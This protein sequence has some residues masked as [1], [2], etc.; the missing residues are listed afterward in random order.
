MARINLNSPGLKVVEK[1]KTFYIRKKSVST[2]LSPLS[3]GDTVDSNGNPITTTTTTEFIPRTTT[4]TTTVAPTTT[5]TTAPII[6]EFYFDG[7]FD[8]DKSGFA[9][10]N[11]VGQTINEISF[12]YSIFANVIGL[13]ISTGV[14]VVSST[15]GG[16]SWTTHQ[17]LTITDTTGSGNY[18][19][20]GGTSSIIGIGNIS[21]LRIGIVGDYTLGVRDGNGSLVLNYV[22]PDTGS[23]I[24]I[25]PNEY[26]K[27]SVSTSVPFTLIDTTT[28]TTTTV[29]PLELRYSGTDIN[30]YGYFNLNNNVGGYN[31]NIT[32]TAALSGS[33]LVG[34]GTN[35]IVT[36]VTY[37]SVGV[38]MITLDIF[39]NTSLTPSGAFDTSLTTFTI[40][41]ITN[42]N[43]LSVYTS[44]LYF[45][46]QNAYIGEL[47]II[48]ATNNGT[49]IQIGC[50]DN[51]VRTNGSIA[52]FNCDPIDI[53]TTTTT[54]A[55]PLVSE[56][57]F[58]SIDGN[59]YGHVANNNFSGQTFTEVLFDYSITAKAVSTTG[60]TASIRAMYSYNGN[61]WY[62]MGS[63]LVAD[64]TG[65][66]T[67]QTLTGT[68]SATN[69]LSV[70]SIMVMFISEY[71]YNNGIP[72]GDT[73]GSIT[74]SSVTSDL[75][76]D[77]II[78]PKKYNKE[79]GATPTLVS[80]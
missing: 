50:N 24:I 9:I 62:T 68:Y 55:A 18:D 67:F 70:D 14:S 63:I 11:G 45:S 23:V 77:V 34:G 59:Y 76:T 80:I 15:N 71:T 52:I 29:A 37:N 2:I 1:D 48:S 49:P 57:Y 60:G 73:K 19:G 44:G 74:I 27:S 28:T 64:S 20:I 58:G 26:R 13:G 65:V 6:S 35:S 54:T 51:Y 25:A 33:C 8:N 17:N 46:G 78:N 31:L 40:S 21:D 66:N 36:E 56:I 32:F 42:I 16:L 72:D 12:D 79:Y 5:T 3:S 41:G 7:V 47:K 53:S 61:S 4:T 39:D 10:N 30:N 38:K 22:T 43:D 75:G 69:F